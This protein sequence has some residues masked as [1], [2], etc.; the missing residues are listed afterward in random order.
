MSS[1]CRLIGRGLLGRAGMNG[2]LTDTVRLG[3]SVGEVVLTGD[4]GLSE[5]VEV[6]EA[7]SLGST[8]HLLS[9]AAAIVNCVEKK[10]SGK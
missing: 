3:G 4:L 10:L 9:Y 6:D 5:P 1:D 7:A 2:L 8:N